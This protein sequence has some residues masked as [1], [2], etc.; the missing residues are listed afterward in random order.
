MT[1]RTIR[2]QPL[3]L[4]TGLLLLTLLLTACDGFGPAAGP[5]PGPTP[6]GTAAASPTVAT[7]PPAASAAGTA[8]PVTAAATATTPAD[9]PR[10]GTL[11]V[12]I[13]HDVTTLNP[14]FVERG[15][16]DRDEAAAQVTSLIFSGLTR[17]DDG[18]RPLPDLAESWD[19]APDGLTLT[20]KLRPGV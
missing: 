20:F 15:T 6:P 8:P 19:V 7:P 4:L 16:G 13:P 12:R 18:L 5:T 17:I 3:R 11:T 2:P 9:V 14:L 10:G 1:H